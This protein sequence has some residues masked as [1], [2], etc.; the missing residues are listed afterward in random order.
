MTLGSGTP[1]ALASGPGEN[2]AGWTVFAVNLSDTEA[3]TAT[4]QA[5]CMK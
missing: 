5:V 4:V 3:A 2:G 1:L